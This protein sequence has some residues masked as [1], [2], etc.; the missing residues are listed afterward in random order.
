MGLKDGHV[1]GWTPSLPP[2]PSDQCTFM[3][4]N[5]IGQ[6][7]G[8]HPAGSAPAVSVSLSLLLDSCLPLSFKLD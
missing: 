1:V 5:G 8:Y 6:P 2:P 3:V 7:C 4:G